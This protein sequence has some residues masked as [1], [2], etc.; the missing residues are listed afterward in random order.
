MSDW[1]EEINSYIRS[2]KLQGL[3]TATL[4]TYK[5]NLEFLLVKKH[6]LD[7]DS[8]FFWSFFEGIFDDERIGDWRF[9]TLV[10]ELKRFYNWGKYR[11]IFPAWLDSEIEEL[12]PIP[13]SRRSE[14]LERFAYTDD[15]VRTILDSCR[16]INERFLWWTAF[17]TGL[18]RK[19]LMFL[20][21]SDMDTKGVKVR[22]EIAKNHKERYI[23]FTSDQVPEVEYFLKHRLLLDAKTDYVFV[24]RLGQ[25]LR[26]DHN[27]GFLMNKIL[28]RRCGFRVSLHN[29]RYTFAVTLWKQTGDIR[30]VMLL[31][32]H[33]SP[34]VTERYLR[35]RPDDEPDI[36]RQKLE[37][38]KQRQ[39]KER[40]LK[41]EF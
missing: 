33:S 32:G 24:N 7:Y 2:K 8:K 12:K 18:R 27:S 28:S 35:I 17:N 19:E 39:K 41:D 36:I 14:R 9:S 16:T 37:S 23:P 21:L 10:S 22:A 4:E 30:L 25:R 15:Q 34:E 11:G 38:V 13:K 6:I 40:R 20:R 26:L 31:L 29:A 1:Q 3:R 5:R